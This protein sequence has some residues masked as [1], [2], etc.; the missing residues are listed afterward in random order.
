MVSIDS[1][2]EHVIAMV[3][4]GSEGEHVIAMVSMNSGGGV[5]KA[6]IVPGKVKP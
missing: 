3:R 6:A 5:S 2:G 4:M 1:E